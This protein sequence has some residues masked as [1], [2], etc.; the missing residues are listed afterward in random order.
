MKDVRAILKRKSQQKKKA[1]Q[2]SL[3]TGFII[4]Q[5]H[6]LSPFQAEYFPQTQR[7][8]ICITPAD[9]EKRDKHLNAFVSSKISRC[10][11][12]T[13]SPRPAIKCIHWCPTK[14]LKL[15]SH[16]LLVQDLP[17]RARRAIEW[18]PLLPRDMMLLPLPS[19]ERS[20]ETLGPKP[21]GHHGGADGRTKGMWESPKAMQQ[22]FWPKISI[23]FSLK[24][25][26]ATWRAHD[27]HETVST[28]GL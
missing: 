8:F 3:T 19:R 6:G 11:S 14:C 16:L 1:V 23:S 10:C 17:H 24:S 27:P 2:C 15:K 7:P 28:H 25:K 12:K 26:V 5:I 4:Q 21:H 20:R 22:G 9:V 13:K 18:A